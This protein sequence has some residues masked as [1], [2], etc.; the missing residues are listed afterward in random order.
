MGVTSSIWGQHKFKLQGWHRVWH[1]KE[2]PWV[3]AGISELG[4][5]LFPYPALCGDQRA[6]NTSWLCRDY[7]IS[8]YFEENVKDDF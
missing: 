6:T 3:G 4:L 2:V 5:Q 1:R 8:N 7:S